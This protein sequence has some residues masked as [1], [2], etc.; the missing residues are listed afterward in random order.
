[1]EIALLIGVMAT[2]IL[3]QV[4]VW[5]QAGPDVSVIG[6]VIHNEYE[7]LPPRHSDMAAS[8]ISNLFR[9]CIYSVML[10]NFYKVFRNIRKGDVFNRQQIK[11]ISISGWCFFVLAIYSIFTDMYFAIMQ[12]PGE[13]MHYYFQVNN[14]I[15]VPIGVGL[16]V[17]S[18]VLQLATEIK[19]EQELVI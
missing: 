19:E 7:V 2:P 16:V 9:D 13:S 5:L 4:L 1:M 14:L 12:S 11:C 18:Y 8:A 10:W 6:G 3:G 15:Y 17:L